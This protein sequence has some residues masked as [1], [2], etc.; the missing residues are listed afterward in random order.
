M[1]K[2]YTVHVAFSVRGKLAFRSTANT[3]RA[4][5]DG[6]RRCS[7]TPQFWA[8]AL[9]WILQELQHLQ[10]LQYASTLSIL[11]YA[12]PLLPRATLVT[13]DPQF[14][15]CPNVFQRS[16]KVLCVGS[17]PPD[18]VDRLRSCHFASEQGASHAMLTQFQQLL[19][20]QS[21]WHVRHR[22]SNH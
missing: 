22:P 15:G 20:G 18:A 17:Q 14:Q 3:L 19:L 8:R 21:T 12:P 11:E 7:C 9:S 5:Q 2:V 4:K 13:G 10:H 16:S 6:T 1:L